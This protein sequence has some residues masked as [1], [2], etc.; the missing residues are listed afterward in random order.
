MSQSCAQT[1]RAPAASTP[2]SSARPV[3]SSPAQPASIGSCLPSCQPSASQR[4]GYP[5]HY[6]RCRISPLLR[7]PCAELPSPSALIPPPPVAHSRSRW[8][9]HPGSRSGRTSARR[10]T[11]GACCRQCV[12]SSPAAAASPA[13]AGVCFV[14]SAALP[15]P[16]LAMPFAPRCSSVRSRA[17]LAASR[18]SAGC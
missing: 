7:S 14:G 16:L 17:L 9:R 11:S 4:S 1:D 18:E 8:W 10:R 2:E 6:T 13:G 15:D 12:A 3:L 5:G